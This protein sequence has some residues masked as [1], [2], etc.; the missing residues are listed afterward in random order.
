VDDGVGNVLVSEECDDPED[1]YLD[2]APEVLPP[3]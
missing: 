3:D 1:A 2:V